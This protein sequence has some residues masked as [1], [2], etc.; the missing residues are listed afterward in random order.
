MRHAIRW[1]W[2]ALACLVVTAVW[3]CGQPAA[4]SMSASGPDANNGNDAA[5]TA[6]QTDA[7]PADIAGWDA[8]VDALDA[9]GNADDVTA[10]SDAGTTG[11]DGAT[12]DA[13]SVDV[14]A[15]ATETTGSKDVGIPCVSADCDDGNPCTTDACVGTTGCTHTNN[16]APCSDNDACSEG[17][18]CAGGK[19]VSGAPKSCDD[20]NA[21][22]DD[23]CV[24][25]QCS[26]TANAG[27]CASGMACS[28]PGTCK[29]GACVPTPMAVSTV[30]GQKVAGTLD[31][32]GAA[33]QFT[34]ATGIA[35]AADGA[36]WVVDEGSRRIRQIAGDGTV[37]TVAGSA[38]DIAVDGPADQAAFADPVGIAL[39]VAGNAYISDA[40]AHTIRRLSAGLVGTYAGIGVAGTVDGPAK[41]AAFQAPGG[42]ALDAQGNLYVAD[43]VAHTIRRV[44]PQGL[45]TTVAGTGKPG[46]MD[47]ASDIAQ[48]K[49]PAGIAVDATGQIYVVDTGN[50]RIRKIANDGTVS[51]VAG[52]GA[53]GFADGPGT[54]AMFAKP[55]GIALDGQGGLYVSEYGNYRI[56]RVLPDGSVTTVAGSG[57]NGG[58]DG[59]PTSA[60]F[61]QPA[62]L[63]WT[64]TG[65]L[66]IADKLT[67][68]RLAGAVSSCDD[69]QSCTTDAC[70]AKTGGCSHVPAATGS[71]CDDSNACTS[72]D[73]CS[74][75]GL[76]AGVSATC[77]DGT[78]CT[79]DVCNPFTAACEHVNRPVACDDGNPCTQTDWCSG[80]ACV[81]GQ[82]VV[83]TLAGGPVAGSQDG[84]GSG[85]LL[86]NPQGVWRGNNGDVYFVGD[87]HKI[88]TVAT[89]GTVTT[90]AGSDTSGNTNGPV[91]AATFVYP[92]RLT[93]D[94]AG[95]LF[96]IDAVSA[97]VRELDTA[98]SVSTLAGKCGYSSQGGFADGP[99]ATAKFDTMSG[100]A[101]SKA[102][103]VYV[104][105]AN[106]HRIR[107]IA[108]GVVSTFAGSA[109]QGM[110]DGKGSAAQFY[111]PWGLAIDAKG[112]LFVGD[113]G[114]I[115]RIDTD[116]T[117]STIA[118][119]TPGFADGPAL[120][121][122][123]KFIL[124]LTFA[125]SGDL[126]I[127]DGQ[128]LR[129]LSP[130][131]QVTTWAGDGTTTFAPGPGLLTGIPTQL[132][133]VAS[134][135][136][137]SV[138]VAAGSR[139]LHMSANALACAD[140]LA[141]TQDDC[142]A[143]S[144]TCSH[145][146]VAVG[147]PCDDGSECTS[148]E[149]CQDGAC[150]GGKANDCDDGDACTTDS[151][152]AQS[153]LHLTTNALGCCKPVVWAA[154][155]DDGT[156]DG[157]T[158]TAAATLN[159]G[160]KLS[161]DF[162]H[163]APGALY[164]GNGVN[165]DTVGLPNAG[166]ATT[167]PVTIPASGTSLT[168]QVWMDTENATQDY[169]QL[170]VDVLAGGVWKQ[171]WSKKDSIT[172]MKTWLSQSVDLSAWAG[173]KILIRFRFDTVD[174]T[175]NATKGVYI[176]DVQILHTCP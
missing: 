147:T 29:T 52:S 9:A 99:A 50:L 53:S 145:P 111:S 58:S 62:G 72:L 156:L 115:R 152:G 128:R 112:R 163:S 12:T 101:V 8:P 132:T 143:T 18:A 170:Y 74:A 36:L 116:G 148:G 38:S 175:D 95:N 165:Y 102:G 37:T 76:C 75:V 100:I 133:S 63:V 1:P 139:L 136:D 121:A 93:S 123:F 172:V 14:D 125:D 80:G 158:V 51:T 85:A 159:V 169:D 46:Y 164:Y 45:V 27:P 61:R 55:S 17:D 109:T 7:I 154:A 88:R 91:A 168:F 56:R 42:L 60:T 138:V 103:A 79:T 47:G 48:F 174:A 87:D 129:V 5:V 119:T 96:V 118:G 126:L 142:D 176:D 106:N 19:C 3:G 67:V 83:T 22:T 155:F 140:G 110:V 146:P 113:N 161:T 137:G 33:A 173:Q 24:A 40:K 66:F 144:L 16:S 124:D 153:C 89:D 31:G 13:E 107:V 28:Q 81:T 26:S 6:D 41:Q 167:P 44:S 86:K 71:T 130:D 117:V 166:T 30:A 54:S 98:G 151:C 59:A 105:D 90:V 32:K 10:D 65:D 108:N 114:T 122:R 120:Q 134:L 82:H 73:A 104:T 21:C 34:S 11:S 49:A 131:G 78:P 160:W 20:G 94:A 70:N 135:P 69:G 4:R 157:M 57:T 162:S 171:V 84:K 127:V 23:V 150:T 77:D 39:D 92:F 141:C 43:S 68:R 64:P 149:A 25:G 35:R 2:N 97:C 15:S